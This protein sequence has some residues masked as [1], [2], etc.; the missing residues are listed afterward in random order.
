MKLSAA[1]P[2][3]LACVSSCAAIENIQQRAATGT[4][5]IGIARIFGDI[6]WD[7]TVYNVPASDRQDINIIATLPNAV[8]DKGQSVTVS[9]GVPQPITITNVDNAPVFDYD[10]QVLQAPLDN[11]D[12]G[13]TKVQLTFEVEG[14]PKWTTKDCWAGSVIFSAGWESWSCDFAC[15]YTVNSSREL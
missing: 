6:N 7:I 13:I 11:P 12:A 2:I 4:C 8:M 5:S 15:N 14:G 9:N 3:A 10:V 1:F